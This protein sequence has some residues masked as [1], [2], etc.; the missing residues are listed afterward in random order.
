MSDKMKA[1]VQAYLDNFNTQNAEEITALFADNATVEDP[2]GT[3]IKKGKEEILAFYKM[4]V[5]N[6]ATLTQQGQTRI[7][8][9][10]A[11][12]AFEV[13]VGGAGMTDV[14]TDIEV[15]L[16]PGS[17]TIHVI[18]TF[19]FDDDGKISEM[20]AFWGPGNIKQH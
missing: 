5:K 16:P 11:A 1:T 4:A 13:T 17:M 9:N 14:D 15:E 10:M 7:A 6:G 18:D 20:R 3:P 8:S 19:A 2:I 12:F